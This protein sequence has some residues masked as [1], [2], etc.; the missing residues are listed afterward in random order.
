MELHVSLAAAAP[1]ARWVEH[2]PQLD[3]ILSA[4]MEID[5]EGY[6]VPPDSPDIG[7][8]WDWTAIDKLQLRSHTVTK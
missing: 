2:I 3:D 1:N 6:A 7:L 5:S 4:P 8:A